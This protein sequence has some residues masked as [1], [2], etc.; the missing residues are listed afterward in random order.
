LSLSV[1]PSGRSAGRGGEAAIAGS[2]S[3]LRVA[4]R[5]A[6]GEQ[7]ADASFDSFAGDIEAP[8]FAV[9]G[10]V[11]SVV[12]V[13][14]V[15]DLVEGEADALQAAGQPDSVDGDGGVL[16]IAGWASLWWREDPAP[17]V[18]PDGVNRHPGGGGNL[19]D[20]HG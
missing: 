5:A 8:A 6:N 1:G 3:G 4:D 12:G 10:S 16:A 15:D 2:A 11:A 14:G 13:E 19:A 20:L 18:E 9:A 17:F 7:F